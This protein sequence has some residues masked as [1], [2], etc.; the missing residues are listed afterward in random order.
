M[1]TLRL[2]ARLESVRRFQDFVRKKIPDWGFQH[3]SA[4][5]ELALEEILVNV[6]RYAYGDGIGDI[7]L[8]CKM[9]DDKELQVEVVDWGK[10]F[11][12]LTRQSLDPHQDVRSRPIG[13]WGVALVR[14]MAHRLEYLNENGKNILIIT[15][16]NIS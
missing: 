5:I 14:E 13:G 3:L 6:V 11:N 1:P 16:V 2:P 15:F 8:S 4:K 7:Q 9:T 10:P 12:P